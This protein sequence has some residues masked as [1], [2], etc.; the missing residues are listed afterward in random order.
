MMRLVK[1][2]GLRAYVWSTVDMDSGEIL[3]VYASRSRNTLTAIKFL[4]MVLGRCLNKP[5]ILVDRG[6]WYRWTLDRLG[7]KYRYQ[8]FDLRN[9]VERFSAYLKQRTRRF[10]NINTWKTHY[11]GLR[12]SNSNNQKPNHSDKNPRRR[13][14]WLIGSE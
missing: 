2:H 14:T 13:I 7:L 8:R 10:N 9:S 4:R 12:S 6:P 3:A 5:L 1:M 11:R